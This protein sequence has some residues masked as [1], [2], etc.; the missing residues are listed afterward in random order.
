[1][2]A[3][4]DPS[5]AKPAPLVTADTRAFW[6]ACAQGVLTFQRCTACGHVQFPPRP[7]C[8]SCRADGPVTER[9][10]GLGT[11]HSHTIVHRAPTPAFKADVP[12]ILA[13]VDFDEGF[14]LMAALRDCPPA[15]ARIDL[16]VRVLFEPMAGGGALPQVRP[17]LE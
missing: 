6:D 16:R 10:A 15:D 8:V 13:L 1:M 5:L 9:S 4:T 11:V 17:L 2:T 14:R 7:F 12:Y 3:T